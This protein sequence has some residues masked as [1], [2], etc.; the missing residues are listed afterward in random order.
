[1]ERTAPSTWVE[2]APPPPLHSHICTP[3]PST[4]RPRH[5]ADAHTHACTE[6]TAPTPGPTTTLMHMPPCSE[7]IG[8]PPRPPCSRTPTLSKQHHRPHHRT[9]VHTHPRPD[10]HTHVHPCTM[11]PGGRACRPP[12][13]H[14]PP[15][16]CCSADPIPVHRWAACPAHPALP[17][18]PLAHIP[19]IQGAQT[20]PGK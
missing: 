3:A 13:L 11:S 14:S 1:M 9:P 20:S 12:A 15:R 10:H 18:G 17:S 7:H 5:H 2:E 19:R 4:Q 6:H 8:P 16:L